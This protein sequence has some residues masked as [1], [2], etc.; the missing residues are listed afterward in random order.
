MKKKLFAFALLPVLGLMVLGTDSAYAF[1]GERGEGGHDRGVHK[2]YLS[3]LTDEE[4][5]ALKE[6]RRATREEHREA[7]ED[8][9]GL[10]REDIQDI[11]EEGGSIGD[12]LKENGITE[13]DAEE[14]LTERAEERVEWKVDT[15]DLDEDE[16]ENLRDRISSFIDRILSK[17]FGE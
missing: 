2:E 1:K 14:F 17:W 6:E 15:F 16:E 3:T 13:S 10:S 11:R 12:A 4:R 9:S 8:F 5:E 7:F